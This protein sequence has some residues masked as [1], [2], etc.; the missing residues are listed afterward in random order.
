MAAPKKSSKTTARAM[1]TKGTSGLKADNRAFIQPVR[2]KNT[3]EYAVWRYAHGEYKR[4]S[5][6]TQ[7]LTVDEAVSAAVGKGYDVLNPTGEKLVPPGD[8]T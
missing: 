6:I 4:Q 3:L 8:L 7:K 1:G 2:V 5:K